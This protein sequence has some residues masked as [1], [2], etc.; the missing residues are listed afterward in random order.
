MAFH[1]SRRAALA[2]I[3]ASAAL[4]A[5][6]SDGR[7]D[8]L[9]DPSVLDRVKSDYNDIVVRGVGDKIYMNFI[10][11][12]CE[13]VETIYE[14][15][16]P[17]I[18]PVAYTRYVTAALA[19]PPRPKRLLEIGLGGGRT[20]SYLHRAMPSLSVTAVEIDPAV[21]AVARKHF[22][23]VEDKRL[24]VVVDDGRKF[25]QENNEKYDII[26]IDAYRGTWVPE[27]LTSV[28]FFELV[29]RRL[30]P[31]GAV[32]QNVEPTTLFYDAMAATLMAVFGNVDAYRT[33]GEASNSVLVAYSGRQ[34][35]T[36][37]LAARAEK[38][39]QRH[40]FAHSLP[41]MIALRERLR[42][43]FR[44]EPLRDAFNSANTL[45]AIDRANDPNTPR[46]RRAECE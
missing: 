39:Q 26:I 20:V 4:P 36:E 23:L 29:K 14:P 21:V 32:A 27:T 9:I 8:I 30:K 28:E 38:L 2:A 16:R 42:G 34:R 18:L 41:D 3:L 22:G 33:G 44:A 40:G 5:T 31:G 11:G 24:Q 35:P 15:A 13:F 37:Q 45:L 6:A 1:L 10:V 12:R 25:I 46:Q 19:Y 17:E 43:P 7:S